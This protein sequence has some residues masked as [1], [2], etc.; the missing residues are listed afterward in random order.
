[1]LYKYSVSSNTSVSG[2]ASVTNIF[3]ILV[4]S[5]FNVAECLKVMAALILSN[6][7]IL[8]LTVEVTQPVPG[9]V[10]T[11]HAAFVIIRLSVRS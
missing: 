7:I 8:A 6:I 5:E 11:F 1:M 3:L 9:H 2:D 10:H 4:L